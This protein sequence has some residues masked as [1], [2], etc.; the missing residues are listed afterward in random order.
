MRALQTGDV[1]RVT[2]DHLRACGSHAEAKMRWVVRACPCRSCRDGA[3]VAVD[4]RSV[5][6]YTPEEMRRE[7]WIVWRHMATRAV[8][9]VGTRDAR[10]A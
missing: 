9:R 8:S 3:T 4:E 7:P 2:G 1:V 10:N 6:E 5:C